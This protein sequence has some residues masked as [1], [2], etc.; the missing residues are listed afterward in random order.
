[1]FIYLR[2]LFLLQN[3]KSSAPMTKQRNGEQIAMEY[4]DGKKIM[5]KKWIHVRTMEQTIQ[6]IHK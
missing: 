3:D 6:L 2:F 5:L 1:M 4:D